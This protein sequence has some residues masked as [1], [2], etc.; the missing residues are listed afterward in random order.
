MKN[1]LPKSGLAGTCTAV[2]LPPVPGLP[3]NGTWTFSRGIA[4]FI[5]AGVQ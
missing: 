3:L 1:T 2:A 5:L 4:L